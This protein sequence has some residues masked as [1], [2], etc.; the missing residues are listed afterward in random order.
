VSPICV[1][2]LRELTQEEDELKAGLDD[3]GRK[4]Q[5]L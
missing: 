2:A 5:R 4:D 1:T 3:T